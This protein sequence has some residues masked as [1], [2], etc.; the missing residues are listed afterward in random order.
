M[1]T[2]LQPYLAQG[3]TCEAVDLRRTVAEAVAGAGGDGGGA[4][5]AGGA[6][7]VDLEGS[8]LA[9]RLAPEIGMGPGSEAERSGRVAALVR[10]WV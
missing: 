9:V 6:G 1:L 8:E 5:R 2:A 7:N 4:G 3:H 10:R